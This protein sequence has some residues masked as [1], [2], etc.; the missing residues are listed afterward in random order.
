MSAIP[1]LILLYGIVVDSWYAWLA[2]RRRVSMSAIGSVIVM[3][4]GLF[5]TAV[6]VLRRTCGVSCL[7]GE[8]PA[9]LG[10]AGKL[11]AV[12]HLPQ[13]DPA[14][15]E[16][17]EH[18]L[19]PAAA[20]AAGVA[21]DGELRLAGLLDLQCSLRHVSV[22]LALHIHRSAKGNPRCLSRARPSSSFLAV[23]TTV[24]SMPRT[25]SILSWLISWNMTCSVRPK[26]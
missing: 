7:V 22:L 18:G 12:R 26:V 20:L 8:L 14:E 13:A 9:G 19:R 6:S 16:L 21:P 3:A 1:A 25:R 17:A 10:H 24:M 4:W 23:V 15:P 2:L 11:A 5:P